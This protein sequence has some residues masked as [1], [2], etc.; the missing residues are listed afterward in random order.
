MKNSEQS[1]ICTFDQ[2]PEGTIT[3]IQKSARRLIQNKWFNDPT[4]S[5]CG[6]VAP[7]FHAELELLT[8]VIDLP[9]ITTV[10]IA[11]WLE[12]KLRREIIYPR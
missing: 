5:G 9:S 3:L 4:S 2:L 10:D 6:H 11:S 12:E 1:P 8:K 7:V